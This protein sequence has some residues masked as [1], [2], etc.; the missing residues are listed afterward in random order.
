MA[1]IALVTDSAAD[2]ERAAMTERGVA[3]V[4]LDIR[5][6]D[7]GPETTREW[8][9][10][11]FWAQCAKSDVLPETSA[12]SPGAFQAAFLAAR[13]AGADGVVCVTLSSKLSATYQAAAA[14]RDGIEGQFP[15]RVVD[16]LL[17]T[18]GEGLAVM[19]GLEAAEAG[20]D[21][22]AVEQAVRSTLGRTEVYGTLD[23]LDNLR[24]GGRIGSTQ[25]FF[26]SL[27]SIKPV[28][29]VRDGLV[30]PES[31]QRTRSR[32]LQY[33]ADKVRD[34]GPIDRLAVVHAAAPDVADFVALV[35]KHFDPDKIVV[36]FIGPVIGT[37]AG[38][39]SVGVCFQH[40]AS[41]PVHPN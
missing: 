8:S 41:E 16:S 29:E 32:S 11:E 17:V 23:T 27:L 3:I 12:P 9:P 20:G 13:D 34:A 4:D 30:E 24:K 39:G 19:A 35:G 40:S 7:L 28:I 37:H 18:M 10:E 25:A 22:D 21:L 36:N 2:L 33:L 6:G 1:R 15:V 5:L 26:G 38:P 31:R 14:A